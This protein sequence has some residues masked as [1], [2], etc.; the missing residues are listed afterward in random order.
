V[1]GAVG[2]FPEASAQEASPISA[3]RFEISI[4]GHSI[5][6]FEELVGI[7]DDIGELDGFTSDPRLFLRKLPGKRKPPTVTLKRGLD[8]SLELS[9]WHEAAVNG[10]SA[11][12]KSASLLTYDLRGMPIAKYLLE[13]AWPAKLEIEGLKAGA[14]E[15]LMESVTLVCEHIQRV[16]P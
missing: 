9:Q 11:A 16:A 15:V 5:A 2:G 1:I 14:S 10:D 7:V 8:T 12:L 13:N 6:M 3:S 4:D